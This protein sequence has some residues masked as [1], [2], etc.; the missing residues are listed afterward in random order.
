MNIVVSD[1][2]AD[3]SILHLGEEEGVA[4]DGFAGGGAGSA[5]GEGG[6][7]GLV[8]LAAAYLKE[9]TD[10]GADHIPEKTVGADGEDEVVAFLGGVAHHS[11]V[12]GGI[13]LPTGLGDGADGCLVAAADFL[14]AAE[15]VSTEKCLGGA[16]HLLNVQRECVEV[17]IFPHKRV[18]AAVDK[19]LVL[20][21]CGVESGVELWIAKRDR[22]YLDSG[23]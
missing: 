4:G 12:V 23:G 22:M 20:T 9:G 7:P 14:E 3:S 10:H 2:S 6:D 17:G 8:A 5:L 16:V 11:D 1:D 13:C 19:V 15:V 21:L 18:P